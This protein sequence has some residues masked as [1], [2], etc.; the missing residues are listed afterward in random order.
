M[1]FKYVH[2]VQ[3][4]VLSGHTHIITTTMKTP[5][6]HLHSGVWKHIFIESIVCLV[7][8]HS[9]SFDYL[10]LEIFVLKDRQSFELNFTA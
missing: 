8:K 3:A 5:S 10:T 2:E 6:V 9:A 4:I 1:T 7:C